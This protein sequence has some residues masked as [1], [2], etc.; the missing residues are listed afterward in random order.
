VAGSGPDPKDRLAEY[1]LY[2]KSMDAVAGRR[3]DEAV[4]LLLQIL[5]QDPASA[6]A[7]RDLASCYLDLHDYAKA[8]ASFEQVVMAAPDDY[9]S[10]FGLGMADKHLGLLDEARPH[11]EAACRLAPRASQCRRELDA[12]KQGAH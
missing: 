7:R 2:E 9:P 6:V 3:L 1:R 5:G 4:A 12:L 8:R 10:Q 11:F